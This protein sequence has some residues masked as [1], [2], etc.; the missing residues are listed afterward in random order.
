MYPVLKKGTRLRGFIDKNHRIRPYMENAYGKFELERG[1]YYELLDADGTEPFKPPY[2]D[3]QILADLKKY[4]LIETPRFMRVGRETLFILINLNKKFKHRSIFKVLNMFLPIVSV[5]IFVLGV[6]QPGIKNVHVG[7]ECSMPLFIF[8]IMCSVILHEAGHLLAAISAGQKID[9]IGITFWSIIPIGAYVSVDNKINS[10]KS[11]QM[12]T[13]LAGTEV[14][15]LITGIC[16][17][18]IGRHY[19]WAY[20]LVDIAVINIIL[21]IGNLVPIP[22][23][24]GEK[25]LSILC[26]VS[27]I[28]RVAQ[29][30]L[31]DKKRRQRLLRT[32]WSGYV[33]FFIFCLV[34]FSRV[35]PLLLI[36]LEWKIFC[37][38]PS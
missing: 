23:L 27:S 18:L 17:I 35:I 30:S 14:D 13:M 9:H 22:G 34:M 21:M 36:L 20:K 4:G 19:D 3:P 32:G 1:L 6:C 2:N 8:L 12:Q 28:G 10:R 16:L 37:S 5:S 31:F 33:C 26:G 24:D 11:E 29:K 15:L 25:A 38:V 7:D